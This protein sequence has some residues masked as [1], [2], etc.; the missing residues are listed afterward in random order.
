LRKMSVWSATG[1][2]AVDF[3]A[4]T[5][6]LVRP[7]ETLLR[8][9]FAVGKLSPQQIAHYREHLAEE[10]LPQQRLQFEAVDA[11]ALELRDF[12]DS[13]RSGRTPRVTGAQGRDALGV[14]E[15]ILASAAKHAWEGNAKGPVGPL[16]APPLS[17]VP[18]PHFDL[19]TSGLPSAW[20]ETGLT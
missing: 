16:A 10:H 14:A 13:I 8:R 15:Q 17:V 6:T 5:A 2:A 4:R 7:S 11:L 18:A 19:S 1:F 12:V 3:A 20:Q 9:Q